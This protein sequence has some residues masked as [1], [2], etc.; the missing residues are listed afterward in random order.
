MERSRKMILESAK[1]LF[2]ESGFKETT[3]TMI[4]KKAGFGYGTA[5]S[6][7]PKGKEEIFLIIMDEVMSE[8]YSIANAKYT[9][10]SKEEAFAFVQKIVE[11]FLTLAIKHQ[12]IL[13]VFHEA[14]GLSPIIQ[15]N[16]D[17]FIERFLKRIAQNV[18]LAIE[19]GLARNPDFD[20]EVVAAILL[21]TGEK[22][23]WEVALNK[24]HK[25]CLTIARNIAQMY[26]E[27]L[28]K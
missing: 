13:T 19:K 14:L 21:Y 11:D 3:I 15:N 22:Y 1:E 4:S 18:E 6:H 20:P 10:K 2:L 9:V 26:A 17:H 27:G 12:K 16:W 24:T 23:L 8:F 7:F 25:D 5:Y 28:Y